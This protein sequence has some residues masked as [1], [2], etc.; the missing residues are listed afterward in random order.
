MWYIDSGCSRH[1]SGDKSLFVE[2]NLKN[3]GYVTFGD[4]NRGKIIGS[5][6][7]G[8]EPLPTIDNVYLVE[9]LQ[10]N[11]LSVSQL[12]DMDYNVSF[13]SSHCTVLKDEKIVG[14]LM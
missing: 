4:N 2:I 10:H 3:Q 5:G 6:K 14:F 13:E 11:L 9:G 1:M 12:C 8:K 7:V